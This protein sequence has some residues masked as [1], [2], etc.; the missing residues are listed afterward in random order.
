MKAGIIC[1]GDREVFP[2][3][4]MIQERR[5]AEKA[6]LTIHEGWIEGVPVA[7]LFSGV[8]KVNAAVAAQILMDC[9]GCGCLINAGTAGGMA[10]DLNIF[11]TVVADEAV[12]H[13]VEPSILTEFHP[14][15]ENGSF[16]ADPK[17]LEIARKAIE[18]MPPERRVMIGRM[19]TGERFIEDDLRDWINSRFTPLTVDMETAAIA[20]ACHVNRKPF[21]AVRT[22]TD[23]PDHRG[24]GAF[25]ENCG[26]A[27]Q[28]SAEFVQIMLRV[29][30]WRERDDV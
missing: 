3:I 2:L 29:S 1:A 9:F 15:I 16:K 19:A 28:L 8:C 20:H 5:T 22:I 30:G 17:L 27:A 23:T 10:P 12:Y 24:K 26:R 14:W 25:E 6:M 7:V 18:V 21:I 4:P 13:D 11:D